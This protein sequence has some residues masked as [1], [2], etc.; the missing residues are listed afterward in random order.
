MRT[1]RKLAVFAF[2]LVASIALVEVGL[3]WHH[4][5]VRETI[6][7]RAGLPPR[8]AQPESDLVYSYVPNVCGHNAAGYRDVRHEPQKPPGVR[9]VV[10]VGDAVAEGGGVRVFDGFASLLGRKLSTEGAPWE[11][12]ILARSGY[13]SAQEI[14][15]LDREAYS[16]DPDLIVWSYVLNDPAHPIHHN[17]SG[18]RGAYYHR[19][20]SYLVHAL[21]AAFFGL[22]ERWRDVGCPEE[23]HA[24]LHCLYWPEVERTLARIASIARSRGVP[25]VFVLH[26]VFEA[27]RDFDAY[28][29][30]GLHRELTS[31]ARRA[32]LPV[33]DLLPAY[34]QH[35]ADD[36]RQKKKSH[37]FDPWHPNELGHQVAAD[38]IVEHLRAMGLG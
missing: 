28:S 16:Y 12:V 38:A 26:P 32:G 1:A 31:L 6:A 13:S 24:R 33:V 37:W 34:E 9:R 15:L 11:A 7:E 22:R 29:L 18:E 35:A 27:G 3:R 2:A 17:A 23:Y 25:V 19:P 21:E 30:R 4:E 14:L 8:C 5:S 10:V 20:V 36:L